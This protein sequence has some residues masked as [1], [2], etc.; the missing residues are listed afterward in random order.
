M[1]KAFRC[2]RCG[3]YGEDTPTPITFG[4][5]YNGIT[6]EICGDCKSDMLR[7]WG[8]VVRSETDIIIP[9]RLTLSQ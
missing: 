8:S 9:A 2:D 1:S 5:G 6:R 7:A 4:R 3:N